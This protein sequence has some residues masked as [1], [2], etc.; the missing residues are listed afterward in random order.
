[1]TF[2]SVVCALAILTTL[3][4][5]KLR[6]DDVQLGATFVCNGERL[7]VENCNIRDLSDSAN[8]MVAHPD[9]P[10]KNG[11]MVYTYESRGS[12]KKLLPTCKQPSSDEVRRAN[13]FQRMQSRKLAANIKKA[14]DELDD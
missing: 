5:A 11:L 13:D 9:R 8:C 6:A 4:Y 3:F 14:N 7:Y 2:R 10:Q 1:M 12:L